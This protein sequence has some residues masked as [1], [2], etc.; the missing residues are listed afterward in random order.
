MK[1]ILISIFYPSRIIDCYSDL[2]DL[3]IGEVFYKFKTQNISY[4]K[5][6]KQKLLIKTL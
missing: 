6:G 4:V 1:L 5:I 2:S 3:E